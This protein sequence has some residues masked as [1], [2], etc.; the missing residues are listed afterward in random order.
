MRGLCRMRMRVRRCRTVV[1]LAGALVVAG[2]V[3]FVVWPRPPRLYKVTILPSLNGREVYPHAINDHGQVV[4]LAESS[5]GSYHLFRWGRADGMRDLGPVGASRVDIN[6]AGQI[7]GTTRNRGGRRFA[8]IEDPD[9]S[10]RILG[11][12][13]GTYSYAWAINN[14][15]QVV[16]T[17]ETADNST[18][19]FIWDV[20]N[21]MQDLGT[22]GGGESQAR[23]IN[24]AGQ[25]FGV[26]D[27]PTSRCEP[28][29][30]DANDGMVGVNTPP[31][32]CHL[33][34]INH[35]SWIVGERE[36]SSG[37]RHMVAWRKGRGFEKLFPL[38]HHLAGE[39][40]IN[41]ANQVVFSEMHGRRFERMTRKILPPL[42]P[43][44]VWDPQRGKIS[45]DEQLPGGLTTFFWPHDLSNIG[46]IVGV[47]LSNDLTC[48][49][50]LLLEPI[51]ESWEK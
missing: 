46:A 39:S 44:Y 35:D 32:R 27:T 37:G 43:C 40:V 38:E 7:A 42:R 23:A 10:R 5:G 29:V 11:T 2:I 17:S 28:F 24:D 36:F 8:F 25:V 22:L 45:L 31:R 47:L 16:G 13:G 15:G 33:N 20:A 51:G 18:H 14:Q 4:G 48:E 19:A 41:D 26:A 3:L 6:N 30:W 9:G 1:C 50:A 21:G 34:G 12:L 49:Q